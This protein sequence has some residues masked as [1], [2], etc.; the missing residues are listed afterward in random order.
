MPTPHDPYAPHTEAPVEE[1]EAEATDAPVTASEEKDA[2]ESV[3]ESTEPQGVP[4][5]PAA[6]VLQWVGDDKDR[7]KE[8][9]EAEEAGQKRVGLTKKLK[10]LAE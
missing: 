9:L 5:G 3:E 2:P 10:E 8:A 6:E 1:V 4:D 7:A